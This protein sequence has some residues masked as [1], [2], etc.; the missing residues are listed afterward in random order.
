M[1]LKATS[2]Y[3]SDRVCEQIDIFSRIDEFF[4]IG[5]VIPKLSEVLKRKIKFAKF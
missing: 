1:K 2:Y 4:G 5:F 3:I